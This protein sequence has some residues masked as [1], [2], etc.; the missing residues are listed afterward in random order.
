MEL[1]VEIST[2]L[3]LKNGMISQGICQ[4][5]E[6]SVL[7]LSA[8]LAGV[9]TL[10][11]I[12]ITYQQMSY[13]SIYANFKQKV[14]TTIITIL[15]VYPGWDFAY[16]IGRSSIVANLTLATVLF[17]IAVV[18]FEAIKGNA[19]TEK[20]YRHQILYKALHY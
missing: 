5:N 7:P 13:L 8:I 6:I 16:D 19:T 17:G 11:M 9:V 18:L 2:P 14:G 10:L 3:Y 15:T 12:G 4:M 20:H 1:I